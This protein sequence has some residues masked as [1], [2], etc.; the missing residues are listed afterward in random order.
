MGIIKGCFFDEQK[1]FVNR[2]AARKNSG[3]FVFVG[4]HIFK[5]H[6]RDGRDLLIFDIEKKVGIRKIFVNKKFKNH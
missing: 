6:P 2:K 3:M 5:L 4:E 1:G